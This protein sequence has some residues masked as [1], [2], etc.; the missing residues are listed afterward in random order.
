MLRG[1]WYAQEL[2]STF[3]SAIGEIALIPSTGGV[4]TVDIVHAGF[5]G[6]IEHGDSASLTTFGLE[7]TMTRLWDRKTE[8]GFPETKELKRRVRD[9]IEPGRDLG[10]IDGKKGKEGLP[11]KENP[12]MKY[13]AVEADKNKPAR[14]SP[15]PSEVER[16]SDVS[17][18]EDCTQAL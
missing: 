12:A 1:A 17:V 7:P 2:L 15:I 18:C 4:F 16:N 9:I 10:H 13:N 8:G 11:A 6:S 3:S 5:P 14:S